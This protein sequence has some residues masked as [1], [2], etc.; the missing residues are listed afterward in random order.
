MV[1]DDGDATISGDVIITVNAVPEQPTIEQQGDVLVSSAASGN[2]WYNS[3]G[4][5]AGATNQSYTPTET[6]D[7]YVIVSNEFGCESEPSDSYYF[8]YTGLVEIVDG[9]K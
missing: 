3:T 7:Y 1:V 4:M 8:I 6:D 5:I 9:K 2:Q